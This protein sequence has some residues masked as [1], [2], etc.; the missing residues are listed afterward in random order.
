MKKIIML[1][2]LMFFVGT[3][4]VQADIGATKDTLEKVYDADAVL[5]GADGWAQVANAADRVDFYK[6]AEEYLEYATN[7]TG[8]GCWMQQAAAGSY[9]MANVTNTISWTI[10]VSIKMSTPEAGVTHDVAMWADANGK[11]TIYAIRDTGSA[12]LYADSTNSYDNTDAFHKFRI[13]LDV[14]ANLI[15]VWRDGELLETYAPS[16][17]GGAQRLI[18]GDCS[19]AI[20]SGT[21]QYEYFAI[22]ATGAYPPPTDKAQGPTPDNGEPLYD[23][24]D[25]LSWNAPDLGTVDHYVLNLR[26]ND[27]NWFDT[28]NNTVVDPATS[29]HEPGTLEFDTEYFWRVDVVT[30][31]DTVEGSTWLFTTA[32]ANPVVLTDPAGMTVAA[33]HP[34]NLFIEH[35]NG[36]SFQW[37]QDGVPVP[38]ET[39]TTLDIASVQLGDE[40]LY[41]CVVMNAAEPDGVASAKGLLMTRR[42]VAAWQFE[43]N[44]AEDGGVLIGQMAKHVQEVDGTGAGVVDENGDPVL[45]DL[46]AEADP[47]YVA[48]YHGQGIEFFGDKE[49]VL[50][51]GTEEAFDFY[52]QGLT[53]SVWVKATGGMG[54]FSAMVS[55]MFNSA[56]SSVDRGWVLNHRNSTGLPRTQ[57]MQWGSMDGPALFPNEFGT[58]QNL[59]DGNWHQVVL[60]FE[61]AVYYEDTDEYRQ[62]GRIYVDGGGVKYVDGSAVWYRTIASSTGEPLTCPDVPLMIGIDELGGGGGIIGVIDDVNIWSYPLTADEVAAL[63]QQDVPGAI[64]VDLEGLEFDTN[65]DCVINLEDFAV[66]AATW[67]NNRIVE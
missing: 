47:N 32:P 43:N 48:G 10:E 17:P 16:N 64:C 20:I 37:Y 65:N 8:G 21:V 67:L 15:Y 42:H 11:G 34:A 61:K 1:T 9:W 26:A 56:T 40:G 41:H 55:K 63:Y 28:A 7:V 14:D 12:I 6:N 60:T 5:G 13:A 45:V 24:D 4:M 53:A 31:T 2:V 30:A 66:F 59:H 36:A 23:R 27:P 54:T 49:H 46:S 33:G 25:D 35:L 44:L 22:D 52:P 58:N 3:S 51:P 19:S 18:F 57:I 39:A 50:V 62:Q 29:P 38:G